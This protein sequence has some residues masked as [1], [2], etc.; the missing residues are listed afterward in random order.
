MRW[1]FRRAATVVLA[2]AL[3]IPTAAAATSSSAPER[4]GLRNR[5]E[6]VRRFI[7]NVKKV[8]GITVNSDVL[9]PPGSPAPPPPTT[10]G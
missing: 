5:T 3:F 8:F 10:N 6:Q 7:R 4:D 2:V 1:F 9:S